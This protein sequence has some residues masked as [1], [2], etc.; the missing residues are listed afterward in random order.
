M[1]HIEQKIAATLVELGEALLPYYGKKAGHD[2]TKLL[3]NQQI[4]TQELVIA[5]LKKSDVEVVKKSEAW[6]LNSTKVSTF[7]AKL[8]PYL[9]AGLTRNLF[10]E[11]HASLLAMIQDRHQKKWKEELTAYDSYREKN[12]E[13]GQLCTKALENAFPK[14]SNP[15]VKVEYTP[16]P[17]GL[18][19]DVTIATSK[20]S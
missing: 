4:L 6:K 16:T 2:F 3:Q 17:F 5:V 15:T 12:L 14:K 1:P 7:L 11:I 18:P 9:S 20:K 10:S 19:S 13:F 8:N